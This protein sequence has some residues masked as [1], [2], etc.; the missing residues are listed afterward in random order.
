MEMVFRSISLSCSMK[1]YEWARPVI[2]DHDRIIGVVRP[3]GVR[4]L[5]VG[6]IS[7]VIRVVCLKVLSSA[8]NLFMCQRPRCSYLYF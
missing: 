2:P 7:R 1:V 4:S 8:L 3:T 6:Y 5:I